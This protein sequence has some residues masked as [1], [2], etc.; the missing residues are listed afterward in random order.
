MSTSGARQW[1]L[2]CTCLP[3]VAE[4]RHTQNWERMH[5]QVSKNNCG[6]FIS[7]RRV[8]TKA[9]SEAALRRLVGRHDT[10]AV[11]NPCGSVKADNGDGFREVEPP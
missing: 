1:R 6:Y 4:A 11:C 5:S 2:D 10:V 3:E 9:W 8:D 7:E